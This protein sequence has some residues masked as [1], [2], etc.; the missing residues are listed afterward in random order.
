MIV[1]IVSFNVFARRYFHPLCSDLP[2]HQ[3]LPSARASNLPVAHQAVKQVL[4]VDRDCRCWATRTGAAASR[5]SSSPAASRRRNRTGASRDIESRFGP[6][7]LNA[8]DGIMVVGVP[9]RIVAEAPRTHLNARTT[10]SLP[11]A[12]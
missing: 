1:L 5:M 12:E 6:R 9:A 11:I 10:A 8:P 3:H 4:S 2:F 7:F